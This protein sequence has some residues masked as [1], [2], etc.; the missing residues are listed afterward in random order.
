MD[1]AVG[2]LSDMSPSE[3]DALYAREKRFK[4]PLRN[5]AICLCGHAITKHSELPRRSVCSPS[6]WLCYCV[7]QIPVLV[8]SDMRR[9]LH[10]STGDGERHALKRGIQALLRS[11]GYFEWLPDS[12]MCFDCGTLGD[13]LPAVVTY[14]GISVTPEKG[15][16]GNQ[17]DIMLCG[18]CYKAFRL[19]GKRK[20]VESLELKKENRNES[21]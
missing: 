7:K 20:A 1:P 9:F 13:I 17:M 6:K 18:E 15:K 4:G 11:G 2:L 14:E 12:R 3:A 16:I 21:Q 19:F 10:A 5:R 8:A